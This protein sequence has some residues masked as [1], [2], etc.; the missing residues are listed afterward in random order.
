[1]KKIFTL[2]VVM[3]TLAGVTYSVFAQSSVNRITIKG[4]EV[5]PALF[6]DII[7]NGEVVDASG[8]SASGITKEMFTVEE[9]GQRVEFSVSETPSG[10]YT[11]LVLDMGKWIN[12]QSVRNRGVVKER[13]KDLANRYIDLMSTK[14]F[15]E[16]VVVY[17]SRPA[18]AQAFSS[19]KALLREIIRK[20][21]WSNDK[22]SYG[23]EGIAKSISELPNVPTGYSKRIFFVSPGIMMWDAFSAD[24]TKLAQELI[25]YD[26]PFYSVNI[27]WSNYG[28]RYDSFKSI[29]SDTQG[30][31]IE[32]TTEDTVTPLYHLLENTGKIFQFTYRSV[33]KEVERTVTIK[34]IGRDS[35]SDSKPFTID[36]TL[37]SPMSV[38][39]IA[40][41][42]NPISS[43]LDDQT[44]SIPVHAVIKGLG[45]RKI[46]K[47]TFQVNGTELGNLTQTGDGTFSANWSFPTEALKGRKEILLE[48]V[49]IDELGI[50]HQG[51]STISVS[52]SPSA[53]ILCRWMG[54]L[55]GIGSSLGR[56]CLDSGFTLSALFNIILIITLIILGVGLWLNKGKVVSVAKEVSVR[57]TNVV[58]RIT[59]RIRKLEPKARLIAI[60]GI[61]TPR[62]E[63]DL[64]GETPIGRSREYAELIFDNNNISRLHCVIHEGT[65][66]NWTIEDKESANGT[67]VNS[68]KITPFVEKEIETDSIIELAPIERGGIKFRFVIIDL[69]PQS[70]TYSKIYDNVA[71][72]KEKDEPRGPTQTIS[73]LRNGADSQG[74][75][76]GNNADP[77]DPSNQKW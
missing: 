41:N 64:F 2:V 51:A 49:A 13:M 22:L 53:N 17:D 73:S 46:N 66:G 20:L 21:N 57:V 30:M 54:G 50:T 35:I 10:T 68:Q 72:E 55:P 47:I 40:N 36:P 29:S 12:N 48:V 42:G 37:V 16:I 24:S 18:V 63:F 52:L 8:L 38:E 75:D 58:D 25:S 11:I 31:F 71:Q 67:F 7:V 43:S 56:S 45:N 27:P 59:N 60:E 76:I 44:S 74:I 61:D 4:V 39:I 15:L 23:Y 1:M 69:F 32:Y 26:A 14:D 19:D 70:D 65:T 9:N 77:S 28:N 62:K 33:A 5:D 3:L 34:Y 6:P